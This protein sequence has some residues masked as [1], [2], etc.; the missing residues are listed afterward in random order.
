MI[1]LLWGAEGD[2]KGG[3]GHAAVQ[4]CRCFPRI[5]FP[6][7]SSFGSWLFIL[8]WGAA[9]LELGVHPLF[10]WGAIPSRVGQRNIL[11]CPRRGCQCS[12][13]PESSPAGR[14]LVVP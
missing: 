12:H 8:G 9:P 10:P 7:S 2:P 6:F 1:F 5:K 3:S 4:N 14:K 11:G 13:A